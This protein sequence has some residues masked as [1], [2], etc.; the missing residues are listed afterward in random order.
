MTRG[1][2]SEG[3]GQADRQRREWRVGRGKERR[4]D[5]G[6]GK[7]GSQ[8]GKK[9][10]GG[11]ESSVRWAGWLIELVGRQRRNGNLT[12]ET[13]EGRAQSSSMTVGWYYS[14]S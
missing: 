14:S 6:R 1:E 3:G 4:G 13:A 5:R 12:R 8:E 10:V 9:E 7:L 2:G 11:R